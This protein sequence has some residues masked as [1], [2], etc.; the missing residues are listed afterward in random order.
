MEMK[1][2]KTAKAKVNEQNALAW[3]LW[4]AYTNQGEFL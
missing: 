4:R 2:E 1:K 3:E